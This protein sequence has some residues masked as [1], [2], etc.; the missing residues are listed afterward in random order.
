MF[1]IFGMG[2]TFHT[3]YEIALTSDKVGGG[4]EKLRTFDHSNI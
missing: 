1:M 3:A 2:E 4:D